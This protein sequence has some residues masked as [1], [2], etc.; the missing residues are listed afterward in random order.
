M[1]KNIEQ[2]EQVRQCIAAIIEQ[3]LHL[4]L[5]PHEA[6]LFEA[7][8]LDSLSFVSLLMQL[9]AS[10]GLQIAM[11]DLEFERFR[12]IAGIATY[13]MEHI[14]FDARGTYGMHFGKISASNDTD[15]S[16][17]EECR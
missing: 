9:E 8:W 1:S 13:V 11:R 3:Q 14:A 17:A 7:G 2:E 10:F 6:D 16:T 15:S 5:P 12:T 4:P